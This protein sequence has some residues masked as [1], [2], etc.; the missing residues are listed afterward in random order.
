LWKKELLS[1]CINKKSGFSSFTSNQIKLDIS[2]RS[3]SFIGYGFMSSSQGHNSIHSVRS[4][5]GQYNVLV[6]RSRLGIILATSSHLSL[7][8][9]QHIISLSVK[10]INKWCVSAGHLLVSNN[11]CASTG[12]IQ[13]FSHMQV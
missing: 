12:S 8:C 4:S 2:N 11:L 5:Y 9:L 3:S 7:L 6:N 13:I 10:G 1:L